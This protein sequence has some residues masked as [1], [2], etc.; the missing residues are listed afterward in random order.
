MKKTLQIIIL[1]FV[2]NLA[3]A[4]E[5]NDNYPA[6]HIVKRQNSDTTTIYIRINTKSTKNQIEHLPHLLEHMLFKGTKANP[7]FNDFTAFLERHE[8]DNNATTTEDFIEL[9][10][11]IPNQALEVS[12][13]RILS[14]FKQPLFSTVQIK[15]E[16]A[17]FKEETLS[18]AG[19]VIGSL[20]SC[21]ANHNKE[22]YQHSAINLSYSKLAIAMD[23]YFKRIWSKA[24]V[25]FLVLTSEDKNKIQTTVNKYLREM[26]FTSDDQV[27][28]TD[29]LLIASDIAY[30]NSDNN[31]QNQVFLLQT[32]LGEQFIS[33]DLFFFLKR[34]LRQA[35]F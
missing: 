10:F 19:M 6:T 12:I 20:Y 22:P 4:L 15:K 18:N 27:I 31:E 11:H 8:I 17:L 14:Q 3:Y 9:F 32:D 30:C 21:A 25:K 35:S 2:S 13:P 29:S 5:G 24:N 33:E 16:M 26:K 7:K 28:P 23:R 34:T 1:F